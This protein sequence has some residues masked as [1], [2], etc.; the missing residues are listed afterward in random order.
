M[1]L[2]VGEL[3]PHLTQCRL[4]EAYLCTNWH[5]GPSTRFVPIHQLYRQ[6]SQDREENGLVAL[7]GSLL[8]SYNGGQCIRLHFHRH[9]FARAFL[10]SHVMRRH[11][12]YRFCRSPHQSTNFGSRYLVHRLSE[13]DE[14]WHMTE[15]TLLYINSKIGERWPRGPLGS[16]NTEGCKIFCNAF[17]VH[18]LAE[19]DEIWQRSG[20]AN[21]HLF[22]NLM[23][24]C[25]GVPDTMRPHASVL[26]WYTCLI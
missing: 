4:G 7:G 2:L 3:G 22:P 5:R 24:F 23:N 6:D 1:P 16:Q 21:G 19:R 25:P 26:H 20:L 12:F 9:S 17:L 18:S 8:V 11:V 13:Q 14:I 10:S 15:R